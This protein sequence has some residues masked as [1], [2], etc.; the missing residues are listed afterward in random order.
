MTI[1][2]IILQTVILCIALNAAGQN[3]QEKYGLKLD[4]NAPTP[5]EKFENALPLGNGRLGAKL[6]GGVW[7]ETVNLN[8][9]TLWSGMPR[10]YND[11]SI[12]DRI[13]KIRGA[14]LEGDFFAAQKLSEKMSKYDNESY[15]P[16]GNIYLSF[17]EGKEHTNYYREL[18]L[19]RAVATVGFGV[20]G[21]NHKREYFVSYPDQVVVIRLSADR[22]QSINVCISMD[23]QLQ[24]CNTIENND[25]IVVRGRAPKHVI[26]KKQAEWDA[27]SGTG[28]ESR[29]KVIPTGG[30]M[31]QRGDSLIVRDADETLLIFSAATEYNGVEKNPATEGRD[32]SA[33]AKRQ[34]QNAATMSYDELL[35]N[36]VNDYQPIFRRV[37]VEINGNKNDR[38]AKAYQWA[39]Y[40][41]LACSRE[42][43]EIPRN[44]QGI[45]NRDVLPHYASNFTLNENPQK[46]YVLAETANIPEA[47]A[48]L[49][50]FVGALAVNGAKTAEVEYGFRGW[51]AHHNSDVWGK[52]TM[53]TGRPC[54]S[55][56]PMGG[57]WLCQHVWERYAYGLDIEYLR[58]TAYPLMKGAALFCLDL[59]IENNE[60]YLA[61]APSTSPENS[62]LDSLAID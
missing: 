48:P 29:L 43:S 5:I 39:R 52:T 17:G 3:Q 19:D 42:N 20:D 12:K 10:D 27:K 9:A 55:V 6:Y 25:E 14:L 34:L 11:P 56:W 26:T 53:A 4:Y 38:Y 45:W 57:V 33:I 22:L 44:E 47:T 18:D 41:L 2:K 36:H 51:V 32:C 1:K 49:I 37:Y 40:N 30:T 59:L 16:L 46:Y 15:Q 60:G 23:T 61:T 24:G 31:M 13:A 35:K 58:Q 8:D 62:F 28:F 50:R 7:H 54:W 21:V